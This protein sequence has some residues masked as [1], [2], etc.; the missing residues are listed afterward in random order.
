MKKPQLPQ[1]N[2]KVVKDKEYK[3]LLRLTSYEQE[4]R[5]QGFKTIAG[6]DEAG[7]GPLAGPVV[8]AACIIPEGVYF[9]YINDSKQLNSEERDSIFLELTSHSDV[10]FGV[11]IICQKEIDRVNIYQATILA[12]LQAVNQLA[13]R[14]DY[15]LVDGL[16]LPH[17][18]LPC[19]KI[20]Q[21][22]TLSQSIAAASIIAKVTRDRLMKEYDQE[23]PA[24]G[25]GQ[26]K[27]YATPQHLAAIHE[28][29]PCPLHRYSFDPI[30]SLK[31]AMTQLELF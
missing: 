26:H 4:A 29:G 10:V 13:A 16:K 11:G 28:H 15:L 25:F 12:M 14:P 1:Q 7:R 23:W 8:A 3:R 2:K 18:S 5:S 27:G 30:K 20:I 19:L 24:Y 22:D 17:P 31:P 21:G 9:R 6:I